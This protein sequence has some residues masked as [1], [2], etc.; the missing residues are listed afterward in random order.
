MSCLLLQIHS[1]GLNQTLCLISVQFFFFFYYWR[2]LF[3]LALDSN[4]LLWCI[5]KVH[6]QIK[7]VLCKC[8]KCICVH[9]CMCL[10]KG[11]WED[12]VDRTLFM[13]M[14]VSKESLC[15]FWCSRAIHENWPWWI[16]WCRTSKTPRPKPQTQWGRTVQTSPQWIHKYT[17][18]HTFSLPVLALKMSSFARPFI[19]N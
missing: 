3:Y 13:Y 7:N 1:S 17:N 8:C 14:C 11:Q 12:K 18:T 6:E 4:D 19:A 9:H 2:T 15:L 16:L 10:M 5:I